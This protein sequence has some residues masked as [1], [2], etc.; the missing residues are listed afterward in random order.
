MQTTLKMISFNVRICGPSSYE[1]LYSLNTREN[2]YGT[3]LVAE[4]QGIP[5]QVYLSV[6][7]VD[8]HDYQMV[9]FAFRLD[10]ELDEETKLA[11]FVAD[12]GPIFG[13][14]MGTPPNLD[15][16]TNQERQKLEWVRGTLNDN[17]CCYDKTGVGPLIVRQLFFH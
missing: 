6:D 8:N 14:L 15:K 17:I 13:C 2:D 10:D 5:I 7:S 1:L 12:D 16:I 3:Y 9:W 11:H 4:Y